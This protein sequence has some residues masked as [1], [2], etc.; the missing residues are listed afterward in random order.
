MVFDANEIPYSKLIIHGVERR[1]KMHPNLPYTHRLKPSVSGKYLA[2]LCLLS[3][4][5]KHYRLNIQINLERYHY[6]R[7]IFL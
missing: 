4:Q 1:S 7:L 2:L 5:M 6:L 3:Q